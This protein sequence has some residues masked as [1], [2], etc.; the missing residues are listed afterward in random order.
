L[1]LRRLD[2]RTGWPLVVTLPVVWVAFEFLRA[3]LISG[4]PWYFLAHT[5]HRVLPLIQI[6]DATGAYGVSL[7]VAFG[8]ALV[9]ELLYRSPG[10]RRLLALPAEIPPL[11][12][13]TWLVQ[14]GCFVGLLAAFLGYGHWRMSQADFTAGPRLALLQG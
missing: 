6:S 7:L 11:T 13:R 10:F 8:N 1:V 4:F 2:R 3:H 5:Q 12:P 9:F 14:A